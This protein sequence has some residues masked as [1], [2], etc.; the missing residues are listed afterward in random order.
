M[1]LRS[2]AWG[3]GGLGPENEEDIYVSAGCFSCHMR[4]MLQLQR[5]LHAPGAS[6]RAR[7]PPRRQTKRQTNIPPRPPY[8]SSCSLLSRLLLFIFSPNLCCC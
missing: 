4:P 5:A 3:R 7:T 2:A 6:R 8:Y 1:G